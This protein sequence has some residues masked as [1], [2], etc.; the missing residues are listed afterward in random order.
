MIFGTRMLKSI[1]VSKMCGL[2][3]YQ[4]IWHKGLKA[5]VFWNFDSDFFNTLR[6]KLFGTYMKSVTGIPQIRTIGNLSF[7]TI[8][9]DRWFGKQP[10]F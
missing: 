10:H 1:L 6:Q 2:W 9:S 3:D 7:P 4:W 8:F 5:E